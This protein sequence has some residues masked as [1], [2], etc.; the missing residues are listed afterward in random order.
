MGGAELS[1]ESGSSGAIVDVINAARELAESVG[2]GWGL[3][4][5]VAILLFMPKIGVVVHLAQLIK[6]DRADGR[7]RKIEADRLQAK[8]HNR[9]QAR[10][11]RGGNIIEKEKR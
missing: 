11:P 4:I 6:E 1:H 5:L 3:A 9:T 7:K 2:P 8:Y 10:L